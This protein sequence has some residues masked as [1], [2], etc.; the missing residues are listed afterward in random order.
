LVPPLILQPLVENAIRYGIE[1]RETGGAVT[2]RASRE[3][4]VLHLEISDDGD[5]FKGGQLLGS[6]NGI[7]LSNTKTRLQELYG[8]KH[9]FKL[10]VN[11]PAGACVK[12]EIPFRLS[13]SNTQN[14]A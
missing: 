11:H 14:E 8:D 2:I 13:Q 10:T 4:E 9:L 6:K 3:R 7:G 12:I 5:G 1:S